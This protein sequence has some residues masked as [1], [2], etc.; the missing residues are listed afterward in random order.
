MRSNGLYLRLIL[1]CGHSTLEDFLPLVV[2]QVSSSRFAFFFSQKS[3]LYC[4]YFSSVSFCGY[5][6]LLIQKLVLANLLLQILQLSTSC[7]RLQIVWKILNS[8]TPL[9]YLFTSR[10]KFVLVSLC[11]VCFP[12]FDPPPPYDH[13][14]LV[15]FLPLVVFYFSQKSHLCSLKSSVSLCS[16]PSI[17]LT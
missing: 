15:D 11:F 5:P 17:L 3:H 6:S 7:S 13:S 2:F 12:S 16:Y 9:K 14:I 8:Q 1:Y 4:F 10:S